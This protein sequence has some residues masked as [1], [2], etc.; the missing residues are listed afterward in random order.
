MV[1]NIIFSLV[2]GNES[3]RVANVTTCTSVFLMINLFLKS[4]SHPV[5]TTVFAV[6]LFPP[7]TMSSLSRTVCRRRGARVYRKP[8]AETDS[9]TCLSQ[10]AQ[11]SRAGR[12]SK[13]D[14]TVSDRQ[15]GHNQSLFGGTRVHRRWRFIAA[16]QSS[17][18]SS[19]P[20]SSICSSKEKEQPFGQHR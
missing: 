12:S 15:F 6:L 7:D 3:K 1:I 13:K 5:L 4:I 17:P 16:R 19:P 8:S 14:F 2:L 18:S 10:S 20:S 9:Q 11:Y